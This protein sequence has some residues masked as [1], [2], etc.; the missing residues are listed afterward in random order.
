MPPK[1]FGEFFKKNLEDDGVFDAVVG[2]AAEKI[3]DEQGVNL[4]AVLSAY[5]KAQELNERRKNPH[6]KNYLLN[7]VQAAALG[8]YR[9]EMEAMMNPTVVEDVRA[10]IQKL[11]NEE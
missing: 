1:I 7:L 4:P 9:L 11:R 8:S 2:K 10:E 3:F 5:D 6:H